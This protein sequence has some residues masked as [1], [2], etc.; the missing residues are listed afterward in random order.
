MPVSHE[1]GRKKWE[2]GLPCPPIVWGG[3]KTRPPVS[4]A[5]ESATADGGAE[6]LLNHT[7]QGGPSARNSEDRGYWPVY[8]LGCGEAPHCS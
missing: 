1:T 5:F 7:I 3:K 6:Q 8:K 4:F 2:G